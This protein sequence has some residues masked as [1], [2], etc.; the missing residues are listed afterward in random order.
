M[1]NPC[2]SYREAIS[3][4]YTSNTFSVGH[5]HIP[6]DLSQTLPQSH[7]A[8][9]KT[10]HLSWVFSVTPRL[11]GPAPYDLQTW[12]ACCRALEDMSGLQ[13]LRVNITSTWI[14]QPDL[15]L[16]PLAKLRLQGSFEVLWPWRQH[17]YLDDTRGYPLY[18]LANFHACLPFPG[19][20]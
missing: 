19:N 9:I 16:D 3:I 15:I 12:F 6:I 8:L 11:L 17:L 5:P 10:F 18:V 7:L 4:L 14:G 1:T 13:N 2:L 20:R